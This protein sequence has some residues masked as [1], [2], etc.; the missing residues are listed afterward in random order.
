MLEPLQEFTASLPVAIQWLG[1]MLIS[2]I[3]F[4]ESYFG[5]PIGILSGVDPVVSITAA[6]IGNTLSM[7]AFVWGAHTIRRRVL[8]SKDPQEPSPRRQRLRAAFNRWGVPGVSLL[9][10]TILPSQITA[11]AMVSFGAATR[12][13]IVWQTISI[14]LWGIGFGLLGMLGLSLLSR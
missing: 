3:P 7:L 1:V 6:I 5:A 11:S 13:V 14:A 4:V 10:Q 9:G 12:A 8:N 2:A